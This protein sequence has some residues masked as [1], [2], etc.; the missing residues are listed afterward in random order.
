MQEQNFTEPKERILL[1]PGPSNVSPRVLQAM[2]LPIMGYLDPSFL[3]VMDEMVDLLR[4]VFRTS[5][6]FTMAVSGTGT[7]GME[8]ALVN[9]LEPG[10]T[11]VIG[12]NGLFGQRMAD[13]ATRCG[14]QV[15]TVS[16]EWGHPLERDAVEKALKDGGQVKL[17][18]AVHAETSTGVL[19]PLEPLAELAR[20]HNALFL[21]DAV[22]SLGGTDLRVDDWGIDVCYSATQKCLG[23]PPGLSPITLSPRA[24]VVVRQRKHPVQ[25]FY[26]DLLLLERYWLTD[27]TYH[28]TASMPMIYALREALMMVLEE[29]LESRFERHRR[30]AEAL[31][32]GLGALGFGVL[33]PVG[34]QT[35]A[36]TTAL[37]PPGIDELRVRRSLLGE[38]GIE[39]GGGFGALTGK[40]WRIGLMGESSQGSNVITLLQALEA[41]L[42]K[43]GLEVRSGSAVAAAQEV[44]GKG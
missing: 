11:A 10:D 20:A 21:V 1:G 40:I 6:Q 18:A 2:T 3:K 35:D 41:L 24:A 31:K 28:H 9:I 33:A 5:N 29:G 13:I 36:L 12:A 23:G 42:D 17:L 8:A 37:V 22:T 34:F 39:I 32:A 4:R 38:Y 43:E 27:R 26:L 16:A 19:Q 25:S 14:A 44:L 30:N 7:A 15:L